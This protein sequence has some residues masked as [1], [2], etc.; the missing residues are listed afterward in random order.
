M[1]VLLLI[2]R[3]LLGFLLVG[4]Y[5]LFVLFV[6][7]LF[8]DWSFFKLLNLNS[9]S[10]VAGASS[11]QWK[12][13]S[14]CAKIGHKPQVLWK[15]QCWNINQQYSNTNHR[16]KQQNR[17]YKQE[18]TI[19]SGSAIS[20]LR[21]LQRFFLLLMFF[22]DYNRLQRITMDCSSEIH[23]QRWLLSAK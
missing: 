1:L 11:S 21:P 4:S 16:S 20:G 22:A 5:Q 17:K 18:H 19:Y 14:V 9:E 8:P 3:M 6:E 10:N 13:Q 15:H 12:H 23:V 2:L 7:S